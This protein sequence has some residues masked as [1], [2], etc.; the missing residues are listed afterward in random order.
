LG[1]ASAA[2]A[3]AAGG[4]MMAAFTMG[5]MGATGRGYATPLNLIA[6]IFPPWRPVVSG[7]HPLAAGIGFTAHFLVSISWSILFAWAM[8][9]LLPERVRGPWSLLL[10]GLGLGLLAWIAT[11]VR[12][13][14]MIDPALRMMP[15]PIAFLAHLVY[16]IGTGAALVVSWGR[17]ATLTE[18]LGDFRRPGPARPGLRAS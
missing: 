9:S 17:T 6:A 8:R 2:A 3:G 18:P 10:G 7:L 14:P 5:I 13:A 11:G 16:G 1:L 12:I 4:A 15:G